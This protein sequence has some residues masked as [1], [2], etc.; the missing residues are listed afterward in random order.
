MKT[1]T[2]EEITGKAR[3]HIKQIKQP[4]FAAQSEVCEA[5]LQMTLSAEDDGILMEPF[6]SFRDFKTQL[7]IWNHKYTGKKPFFDINGN[8]I[9]REGMTEDEII[10]HILDWSAL[11][12]GSRHQWG[13]EIDVIDR[14]TIPDDYRVRLLPEETI[15]G[16]VFYKLHQ[17]LD[18]HM[19]E[20][21]FFRPYA[22]F[23]GGMNPEP[24]HLSYAPLSLDVIKQI[25]PI[26][27][28]DAISDCEM[29]GK[30][31]TLQLIPEIFE[32]HILNIVPP[33][34]K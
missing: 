29:L 21:G 32:K 25:N 20:F 16:G 5:F 22:K 17:W 33:E 24:W 2:T 13:T 7:R 12:G 9:N 34:Y 23:I 11:P 15:E 28:Q 30:E 27:L 26:I 3:T 31:R 14:S 1:L 19:H 8:V 18:L 4:R 10:W 6:S